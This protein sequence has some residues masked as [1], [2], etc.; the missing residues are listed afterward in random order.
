MTNLTKY[1]QNQLPLFFAEPKTEK[2]TKVK[3]QKNRYDEEYESEGCGYCPQP[4]MK[5]KK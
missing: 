2:K 1:Q 4:I 3:K 5:K